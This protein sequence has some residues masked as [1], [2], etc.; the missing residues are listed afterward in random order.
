LR[1]ATTFA[2]LGIAILGLSAFT[3]NPFDASADATI[4]VG[5]NWY[6]SPSF[7]GGT[8]TTNITTGETVTWSLTQGSHT[9]TECNPGPS[10]PKAGGFDSDGLDQGQTYSRQFTTAGSYAYYCAFHPSD[11]FGVIVVTDPTPSPTQAP[12]QPG[13]TAGPT[14]TSAGQPAA[15]A[16]SGGQPSDGNSSLALIIASLG[17]AMMLASGAVAFGV[18][19][20]H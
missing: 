20:R 5:N 2:A 15:P 14:Q 4:E 3:L 10:C 18:V 16:R 12:T 6:C 11:M 13:E 17:I 8:C 1:L 19:R 7:N 9:V